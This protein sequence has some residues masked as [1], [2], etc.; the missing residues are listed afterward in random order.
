MPHVEEN[1]TCEV[2]MERTEPTAEASLAAMRARSRFGIAM[3]AIIK[4]MA[5]TINNSISEKPFCFFFIVSYLLRLNN[6]LAKLEGRTKSPQEMAKKYG[7]TP[8]PLRHTAVT[9]SKHSFI[10]MTRKEMRGLV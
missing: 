2:T 7:A 1:V 10:A 3:A 9:V 8:V 4:I 6:R 5:T